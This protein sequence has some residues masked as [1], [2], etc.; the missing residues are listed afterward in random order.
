MSL[1]FNVIFAS[2]ARSTH[3]KLALDALRFL[4]GDK[5]ELWRNLFLAHYEPY[6]TGSK[7]PDD[8]FKDFK[9]HVLH[10]KDGGWGG[11][12]PAARQWY[13]KTVNALRKRSWEEA[14]YAAGVLS[15]YYTD[16]IQPFHT[17][18]S[19]EETKIHRAAEWSMCKC[20]HEF[21]QILEQ[22]LGGYPALEVPGG[23]DWLADM[24]RAGAEQSNPHYQVVIDHYDLKRGVK[25]PP[26]GLDQEI[27]DRIAG[28]VGYAVVGFARIL[29]QAF[30]DCEQTPPAVDVSLTG[31]IATMNV[32]LNWVVTQLQ[33]IG[34][35]RQLR[36]LYEEFKSTGHVVQNLREDDRA[37]RR[38]YA[39]EVLQMT[40]QDLDS[41]LPG[42]TGTAFREGA[43]PR[44]R[45]TQPI[46]GAAEATGAAIKI[47][48]SP[49]KA[50]TAAKGPVS[51]PSQPA[52]TQKPLLKTEPVAQKPVVPQP[53]QMQSPLTAV[54]QLNSP[55][56]SPVPQT[57]VKFPPT[58]IKP[59]QPS[60]PR[61]DERPVERS[62]PRDVLPHAAA[63]R[64][65]EPASASSQALPTRGKNLQFY[66]QLSSPLADAPSIGPKM[67]ERLAV[68][69]L[70]T[71]EDFLNLDVE[72]ANNKLRSRFIT[73]DTLRDWQTQATLVCRIP[74]LRGHDAQLLVAC[75]IREPGHL[76]GLDPQS[77]FTR[78][79]A[80]SRTPP[81]ERILRN[82]E[83]PDLAEVTRWIEYASH[84]RPLRAAG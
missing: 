44:S 27:K 53:A 52:A 15:H 18:Q 76:I 5:A 67:A 49:T 7:A 57:P 55:S 12:I 65:V 75:G 23:E 3:H 81:G 82:S 73:A 34:E 29:E 46:F 74:Q 51:A 39:Q 30:E 58:Q 70:A 31:L 77:L 26:A 17:A 9:N 38:L 4:R 21:Q 13:D 80:Y 10:V 28:L 1:L 84:A 41:L 68:L 24:V 32:P 79:D 2:R 37:V 56:T 11:A 59:P 6:L 66:L 42:E 83:R 40:E 63:Q 78:V 62:E 45:S 43:E 72:A 20:Y 50:T 36:A 16:P 25:D 48:S 60:A 54:P 33:D 19:E 35:Q 14:V 69:N 61:A 64:T 22:D 47:R 8:L 71:V